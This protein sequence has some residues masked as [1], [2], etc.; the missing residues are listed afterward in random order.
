MFFFFFFFCVKKIM[1]ELVWL[2]HAFA[3]SSKVSTFFE[4]LVVLV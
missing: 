1:L 2:D 4:D 3:I